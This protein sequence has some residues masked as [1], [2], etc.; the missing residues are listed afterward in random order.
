[1]NMERVKSGISGLDK[2]LK[3][4]FKKGVSILI[5]GAPGTGKTIMAMQF[6]HNGAKNYNENGIFITTEENLSDLKRNAKNLGMDIEA[7]EKKEKVFFFQKP[8]S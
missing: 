3:G 6:I 4:G 2:V 5:T 1:M 7:L 8:I